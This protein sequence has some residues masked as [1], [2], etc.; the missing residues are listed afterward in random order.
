[1][2]L[3]FR[4]A[5][6]KVILRKIFTNIWQLQLSDMIPAILKRNSVRPIE[7]TYAKFFK[8]NCLK[9]SIPNVTRP[10]NKTTTYS[11]TRILQKYA[12]NLKQQIT[13]HEENKER[14]FKTLTSFEGYRQVTD[15]RGVTQTINKLRHK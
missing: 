6:Y 1:M 7:L 13:T 9:I 10:C 14:N 11:W 15:V 5:S 3:N 8:L 4:F 2:R 12:G